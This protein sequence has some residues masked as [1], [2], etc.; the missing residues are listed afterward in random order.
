ML[1]II[2]AEGKKA[3]A[4]KNHADLFMTYYGENF[5]DYS[6]LY[7]FMV[8]IKE[9]Y[10]WKFDYTDLKPNVR[11][12]YDRNLSN[13]KITNTEDITY[14]NNYN[15]KRNDLVNKYLTNEVNYISF[16]YNQHFDLTD[17][18]MQTSIAYFLNE[19]KYKIDAGNP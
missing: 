1:N 2:I 5:P 3:D 14:F 10:N 11:Y 17:T 8:N 18:V 9:I 19:L 12:L 6:E 15:N 7:Y 13:S 4:I 16:F